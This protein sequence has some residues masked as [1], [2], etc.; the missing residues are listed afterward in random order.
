MPLMSPLRRWLAPV[1]VAALMVPSVGMLAMKP[2]A[3]SLT[4][5]RSLATAPPVPRATADWLKLPRRL[6]TFVNDHFAFRDDLL[7]VAGKVRWKL[8]Q[9]SASGVVVQGAAGWLLLRQGLLRSIGAETDDGVIADYAAFVCGMGARMKQRNIPFLFA[10]IPGTA[11]IYPESL[12]AWAHP[13]EGRNAYDLL[14]SKT[15]ACG[16]TTVDLRKAMRA[17]KDTGPLYRKLDTHWTPRGALIGYNLMVSALGRPDWTILPNEAEWLPEVAPDDDLARLTGVA[18]PPPEY[19]DAPHMVAFKAAPTAK[20]PISGLKD[21]PEQPAFIAGAS[22]AGPTVLV[23][24]DSYTRTFMPPYFAPFV[25]RLAWIHHRQCGVDPAVFD[26][27]KPDYVVLAP[28][29]RYAECKNAPP[30][31]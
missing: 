17:A 19:Q 1:V 23:V 22:G 14:E 13:S 21:D 12:P 3:I 28:A 29:E 24:G 7:D 8:G 20:Q 10:L 27:V 30:R 18:R 6:D 15:R 25:G 16:V 4:E 26:K 9:R 2:K 5:S 11:A 31:P